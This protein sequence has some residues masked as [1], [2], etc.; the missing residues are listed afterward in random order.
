M[1]LPRTRVGAAASPVHARVMF[2]PGSL[3]LR[4]GAMSLAHLTLATGDVHKA[5]TFFA[6]ALGWRPIARPNNIGRPAAWLEIAPGQELHL[7]E[8]ADFAPSP[9][10]AEFGRHIAI[11]FRQG[12]FE[13]LKRRLLR[14][15]ATLIDPERPTP[16]A[17]FF[18]RSPDGYVFE[19]VAAER[20]PEHPIEPSPPATGPPSL[21]VQ[22]QMEIYLNGL[23]G[24]KPDQPFAPEELE[25][26]ARA[27]LPTPAY[28]YV[29]GGAGG[30]ETV[31]ANRDAFRRWRI[32]PRF[33]RDVSR[34]DL[35]IELLGRRLSAPVL[36][37]PVGVQSMLHP[38]A[39]LAV[40]RAA[41]SLGVPMVLS[42]VS[43]TSLEKV[44]EVLG[45]APHWF[46]LYWPKDPALAASLVG[47]AERAGFEAV[48]VT[49][50]T[51][52]LG[53]RER[54]LQLAWLPFAHG[55]GIANYVT[56]PAFRAGLPAPPE[57]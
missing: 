55:Q 40:A 12:D 38:E 48:V 44:A 43:S 7:V 1:N 53:W 30:E 24:H 39:E 13:E 45:D 31:R 28:I 8:V 46:Q 34:R 9:F 16:F 11:S 6:E 54:D 19:V 14:H 26:R 36:L 47:R 49:L 41:R 33:L 23:K 5:E 21:G 32:V 15:G 22:R 57:Q 20:E 42:S 27:V 18:F 29:A 2:Q 10:E 35:A 37:A 17:R 3:V 4:G 52:L 51:Y 50:D 25:E 56:D